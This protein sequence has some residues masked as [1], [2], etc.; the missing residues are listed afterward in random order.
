MLKMPDAAGLHTE[1][2]SIGEALGA[3]I[4]EARDAVDDQQEVE[5]S[6]DDY[7]Q[8]IGDLPLS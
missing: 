3:A 2:H 4:A 6:E 7:A 5:E 8:F 1:V